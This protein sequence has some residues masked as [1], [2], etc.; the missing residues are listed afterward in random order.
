MS[1][2]QPVIASQYTDRVVRAAS[3]ARGPLT[4]HRLVYQVAIMGAG[5]DATRPRSV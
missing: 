2:A 3:R 4:A 5:D 1:R